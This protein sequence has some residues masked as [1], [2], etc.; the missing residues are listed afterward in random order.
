MARFRNGPLLSWLPQGWRRRV[1]HAVGWPA[2]WAL[3]RFR[4]STSVRARVAR[5]IAD[6]TPHF[7]RIGLDIGY[8]YTCGAVVPDEITLAAGESPSR[9]SAERGTDYVPTGRP[10][11][12]LPHLWLDAPAETLSTHDL[13][14]P[15]SFTLLLGDDGDVWKKATE[16]VQRS[17][18]SRVEIRSMDAACANGAAWTALQS[19]CGI[20]GDGALLVRP[21]GHVAWRQATLPP[22]PVESLRNALRTCC[23]R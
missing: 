16:E 15:S 5:S 1:V 3:A 7:D 13:L 2:L 9:A 8:T 6:Q 17:L 4:R 20:E 14:S 10:G 12:R 19:V 11:A 22:R 18:R 23:L 21:D